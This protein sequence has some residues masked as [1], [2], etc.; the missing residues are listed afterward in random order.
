MHPKSASTSERCCCPPRSVTD[1]GPWGGRPPFWTAGGTFV[2]SRALPH[3]RRPC[4]RPHAHVWPPLLSDQGHSPL[5]VGQAP[6]SGRPGS[7]LRD[8]SPLPSKPH[9]VAPCSPFTSPAWHR[10]AALRPV[11]PG[12]CLSPEQPHPPGWASAPGPLCTLV[13]GDSPAC[14]P[15]PGSPMSLSPLP[16]KGSQDVQQGEPREG[17]LSRWPLT[18]GAAVGKVAL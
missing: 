2:H 12:S 6:C 16:S 11:S 8:V 3:A 7:L 15:S 1:A 17:A 5:Q 9:R 18:P 4:T 13:A 10:Q 14:S